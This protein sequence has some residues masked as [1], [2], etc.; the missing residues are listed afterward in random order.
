[1][2]Q[3]KW[4]KNKQESNIVAKNP[5][6]YCILKNQVQIIRLFLDYFN[7]VNKKPPCLGVQNAKKSQTNPFFSAKR[8][9]N[10]TKAHDKQAFNRR[11]KIGLQLF[12]E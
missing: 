3:A 10:F 4:S 2:V 5:I 12:F 1:M 7:W 8:T 6:N 9:K 11:K